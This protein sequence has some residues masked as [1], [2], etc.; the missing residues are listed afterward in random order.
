MN[1]EKYLL[2]SAITGI[3]SQ[4]LA[5]ALCP[6]CCI[7][8]KTTSYEKKVFKLALRKD[9]EE[10]MDANKN[11][12]PSCNKGYHGR[13]AVQEVL[14]IDD[15]IKSA[16]NNAVSDKTELRNLVYGTGNVITL[17][18]DGLGK[19]LDGFTTFEE[20]YRIIE[21]DNDIDDSCLQTMNKAITEKKE[22][23]LRAE[24]HKEKQITNQIE[25]IS[26]TNVEKNT[27]SII[28][29]T[30]PEKK[31]PITTTQAVSLSKDLIPTP[32]ITKQK[33]NSNIPTKSQNFK[34]KKKA[35]HSHSKSFFPNPNIKNIKAKKNTNIVQSQ[36][37]DSNNQPPLQQTPIIP[38]INGNTSLDN[39]KKQEINN[40]INVPMFPK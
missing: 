7:K 29:N 22:Q 10:I 21:I 9:I 15:N 39:S 2:S 31:V 8:R 23:E 5:K 25:K 14:E 28:Q 6:K 13:I 12:C 30:N 27:T 16:I 4:R 19:I 34:P 20:I 11:G 26:Q 1:V 35:D 40:E 24:E 33:V 3:I 17:L 38:L 37:T 18:Q 32:D 36:K